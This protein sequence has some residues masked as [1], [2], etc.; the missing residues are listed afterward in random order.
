MV[1]MIL[2]VETND[3]HPAAEAVQIKLLRNAGQARRSRLM[4]SITQSALDLSRFGIRQHY[5][6]L[7]PLEQNLKF[8]ELVYGP[9][10]AAQ[11]KKY[12]QLSER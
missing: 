12:L 5:S 2:P 6:Y 1:T 11:L 10:L 4:L 8:V 9:Y 7:S 3:T